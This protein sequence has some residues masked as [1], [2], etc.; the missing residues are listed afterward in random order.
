VRRSKITDALEEEGLDVE[1][2]HR[3][4]A[5]EG[6]DVVVRSTAIPEDNVELEAARER[7]LP[8][9]H[10]AEVL[11]EL[12]DGDRVVGVTGTHGKGTVASMLA[13][14]LE[15]AGREPSF[16]VGGLMENFGTNARDGDGRWTVLEI[17]E[18]DGTHHEFEP[19]FAVCNFLEVDHL[20]YY[21]GLEDIIGSMA[22][23]FERNPRLK[24]AF[25][26]LDCQGNRRMVEQLAMR[27][28]GY[29][30]C[31]RTEFRGE[32]NGSDPY[33]I[34]FE[35]YNRDEKLGAFE[36]N[37]PGRYNVVNALAAI[38]VA[39]RIGVETETIREALA[40]YEGMENRFSIERG[41]G[42]TVVKD[43]VSHPTGIRKV[44]ESTV[45]MVDGRVFTVFKPYRYTLTD[46]LQD[47]YGEAF[48][49]AD[50]AIITE[51]FD[52]GEEPI[53]GVDA[54]LVVEKIRET[55]TEAVFV[56][57]EEDIPAEL[58]ERVEPGDATVFFG[59]E[60]FFEMADGFAADLAREAERTEP[61][62]EAPRVDGPLADGE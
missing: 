20:N 59:A 47:E 6:R 4:D 13:W 10:R 22:A 52:A 58:R 61:A 1:I 53:P 17:D 54:E 44:L 62:R 55:G 19:D 5:V 57:Q 3:A 24:E 38:A 30:T 37:L 56:P 36:L 8:I 41:G 28:T 23:F 14:I 18:S 26:N 34:E 25:I 50:C 21:E 48:E 46:Y 9:V 40:S 16:V 35:A 29:G 39:H 51:M 12:V 33:P 31:H 45:D 15:V 60:D 43:Y 11:S 42:V 27:P 32:L 49:V 2:G 7:G